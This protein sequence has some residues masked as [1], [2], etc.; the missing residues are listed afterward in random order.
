MN[1]LDALFRRLTP[2]RLD[3]TPEEERLRDIER[4]LELLGAAVGVHEQERRNAPAEQGR[5]G[6]RAEHRAT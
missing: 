5:E 6:R 3:D 2:F 4:R 1:W